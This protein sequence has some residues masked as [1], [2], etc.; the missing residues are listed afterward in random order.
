VAAFEEG[1]GREIEAEEE[2]G[3]YGLHEMVRVWLLY[4]EMQISRLLAILR[5]GNWV[6]SNS[7]TTGRHNIS[8]QQ[9]V[10]YI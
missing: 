4:G 10:V 6:L 8:K 2:E 9:T 7:C 3:R 5:Y 1:T